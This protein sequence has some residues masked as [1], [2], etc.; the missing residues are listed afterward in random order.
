VA[1]QE[2]DAARNRCSDLSWSHRIGRGFLRVDK[3]GKKKKSTAEEQ[4]AE[5]VAEGSFHG[6]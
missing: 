6:G 5:R 4:R 3:G 2:I 1:D